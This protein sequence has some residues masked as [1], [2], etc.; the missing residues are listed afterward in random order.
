MRKNI[1]FFLIFFSINIYAQKTDSTKQ[2]SYLVSYITDSRDIIT[3]PFHWNKKQWLSFG[4]ISTGTFLVHLYDTEINNYFQSKQTSLGK[5]ISKYGWEPF[6]S[7][8]YSMSGMFLFY[9]QGSIRKNQRSKKVALL[10][11][12]AYLLSGLFAQV[13]KFLINRHRPYH[14]TPSNPN[15]FEGP[16]PK[17][18]HSFP[19]GHTTSAFSVAAVIANEYSSTV[20]VPI[21]SYS[22][23]SMVGISRMYDNKHWASD[24]LFG[25]AFGWSI[26][27]L[28]Q[29]SKNW[30]IQ[31]T[32][33]SNGETTGIL[34]RYS[35]G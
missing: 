13:P 3:A 7:G 12:K 35:L 8:V 6:G 16:S 28:V 25:A 20:W 29:K 31:M 26:G 19:S 15:I 11:I 10:G 30:H 1:L 9:V 24:I 27:K 5:N 2:K 4:A 17:I 22:L 32:P 33:Y 21:V 34:I 14:D 18:F 23:A